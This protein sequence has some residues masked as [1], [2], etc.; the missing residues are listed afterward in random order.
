MKQLL[1]QPV[2]FDGRNLFNP[3]T[4]RNAGIEYHPI[5]RS[6]N[7]PALAVAA[8]HRVMEELI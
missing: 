3:Q 8:P 1:R 6:R 4:L 2:V 5:G 7:V